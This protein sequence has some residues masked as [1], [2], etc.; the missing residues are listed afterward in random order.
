MSPS[1]AKAARGLS[2]AAVC[3]L[4]ATGILGALWSYDCGPFYFIIVMQMMVL[5]SIVFLIIGLLIAATRI[6]SLRLWVAAL[7]LSFTVFLSGY[8]FS[9]H[10]TFRNGRPVIS[11]TNC[12]PM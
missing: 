1:L 10:T 4:L 7:A 11:G 2:S 3:Y 8:A 6:G 5:V 9:T 12:A